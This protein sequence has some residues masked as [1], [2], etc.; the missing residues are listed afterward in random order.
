MR[1]TQSR[2]LLSKAGGVLVAAGCLLTP[3]A[4]AAQFPYTVQALTA[5][6]E[7]GL[8]IDSSTVSFEMNNNGQVFGEAFASATDR[9]PVLWTDGVP[10]SLPAPPAN[11]FWDDNPGH[12]FLNDNGTAVGQ[13]VVPGGVPGFPNLNQSLIIRWQNGGAPEI[14]PLPPP[15]PISPCPSDYGL[16]YGLN[17]NGHLL[18]MSGDPAGSCH[19]LWL[20]DGQG[21]SPDHFQLIT[22]VLDGQ[23]PC[24]PAYSIR[25]TGSHLNDFDHIALEH[26]PRDGPNAACMTP[27]QSGILTSGSFAPVITSPIVGGSISINN[28][29]H[30]TMFF[31][32]GGSSVLKLW[33]GSSIVD[34]GVA[35]GSSLND[36]GHLLLSSGPGTLATPRLYRN[37]ATTDVP[38]P[39]AA[40]FLPN[41]FL[42]Q[43]AGV[44]TSGLNRSGQV[45]LSMFFHIGNPSGNLTQHPVLLTPTL[46]TVTLKVN[47]QHPNPAAV[48]TTGPMALT[49]DISASAYTAPLTW[50]WGLVINNQLIWITGAGVSATPAPLFVAP[51]V[52]IANA[53]LLDITLPLHTTLTSF[54]ILVGDGGSPVL[55]DYVTATRP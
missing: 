6:N 22:E 45:L 52:A 36:L 26:G 24:T 53:T 19:L 21:G 4:A 25:A 10:H 31:S 30:V 40:Q 32:D 17:N 44:G 27:F 3:R 33:N 54:F 49:L 34:F 42:E 12:Q 41:L 23:L 28:S 47:G 7:T 38:L 8:S 9:R 37:G 16:A 55:F 2:S 1:F 35:S 29:D 18:M 39:T 14:V 5:P 46:P 51:P 15:P 48:T 11:H 50:Y 43:A 20:W 13:V